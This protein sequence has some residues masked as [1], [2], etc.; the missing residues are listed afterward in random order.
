MTTADALL[1]LATSA[2]ADASSYLINQL[3]RRPHPS[4]HGLAIL[5]HVTR[6]YS[7]PSG[8][9]I[10]AAAFFGFLLFLTDQ[11]RQPA[12]WLGPVR[13]LSAA[14]IVLIGPSRVLEGEHWPSDV[15]EGL[16]V[17]AFW[18]VLGI[19]M[20]GAAW[21]RWPDLLGHDE[22]HRPPC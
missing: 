18:R 7:F 12:R 21:C 22:P 9:V 17:G 10:H 13:L 11:R 20:Y 2:V 16:L 1:A 14:L 5:Q 15:P 8:H 4:G 3:V 6:Y 19:H